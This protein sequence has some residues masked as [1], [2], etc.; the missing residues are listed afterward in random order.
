VALAPVLVLAGVQLY[1]AEQMHLGLEYHLR[2]D[3]ARALPHYER[4]ARCRPLGA[5]AA[6]C[7]VAICLTRLGREAEAQAIFL[8]GV[9]R[10]PDDFGFLD[11]LADLYL[12][13]RD[14]RFRRPRAAVGL[15]ERMVALAREPAFRQY[16]QRVLEQARRQAAAHR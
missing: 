2:G 6:Q 1:A 4:A 8:S 14:E 11:G 12:T 13:A 10:C 16:A 5:E 15:A 7:R 3:Y 9:E